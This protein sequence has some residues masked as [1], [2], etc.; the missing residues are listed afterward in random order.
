MSDDYETRTKHCAVIA[1]PLAS[2]KLCK[3]VLKLCKKATKKKQV[4]R[5]VKEVVK[6]IRKKTRGVC[7]LAG[8]IS[9]IDVITH[10]PILCEDN[11]IPYVYVPSKEDLASAG[12]TKRPTS[13]LLIMSKPA[14]GGDV[15]EELQSLYG[16]VEGKMKK[17]EYA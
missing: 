2:E 7:I 9:P 12:Q 1:K 17:L 15:D 16:D 11:D 3:K 8:D 4:K 6:A 5:G 10:L 14:K 13:C